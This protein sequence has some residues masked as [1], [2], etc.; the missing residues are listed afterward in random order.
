[1]GFPNDERGKVA[2]L[3]ERLEGCGNE[4]VFGVA[5]HKNFELIAG[6]GA[7]GD[8]VTGQEDFAQVASVEIQAWA[9]VLQDGQAI[10]FSKDGHFENLIR[11]EGDWR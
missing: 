11:R 5:I 8:G 6:C 3:G 7:F 10:E 1:V 9:A 4:S 2:N